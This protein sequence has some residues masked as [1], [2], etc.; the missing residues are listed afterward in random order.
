MIRM[1]T[2]I[3][4]DHIPFILA[5]WQVFSTEIRIYTGPPT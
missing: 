4:P 2:R 5:V 3:H 1:P